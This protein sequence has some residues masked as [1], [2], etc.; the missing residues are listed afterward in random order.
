MDIL[1]KELNAIYALQHL[2]SESL[3]P[4]S[5]TRAREIASAIAAASGGCTV[6][7][8][9]A[10]D[11][12]YIYADRMG[13]IIGITD[14]PAICKEE[15]SSDEDEIYNRIH[16]EDLVEKRMLEYEFFKIIHTLPAE[17]KKSRKATC[18]LRIKDNIGT[19]RLIDNSTQAIT[20]SPAGK[21]WLILCCYS[22]SPIDKFG[23]DISPHILNI[24]NGESISLSFKEKR[25]QI[26]SEREKEVLILIKKG[27]PSKQIASML[28]I[29]VH[30]VNR[31]RQNIIEK[32]S[33]GNSIEAVTAASAM[34]LL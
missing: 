9:A 13:N 2:E 8:D 24:D 15:S 30:T 34:N 23:D 5:V 3:D 26:L 18:R 33:V 6:I 11:R 7:T 21:I 4:A 29:S 32:L 20:L 1:R 28:G 25:K 19:Y 17:E 31:H 12:C 14:L 27:Y 16:P 22:I 10:C